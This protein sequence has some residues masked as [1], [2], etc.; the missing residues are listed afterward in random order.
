MRP[1][2]AIISSGAGNNYG[3]PSPE[4]LARLRSNGV[5]TY[6]TDLDGDITVTTDGRDFKVE[7]GRP[8]GARSAD[9]TAGAIGVGGAEEAPTAE[10]VYITRTGAKYHRDGCQYL[11]RSRIPISL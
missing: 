6:R 3:H 2:A 9:G 4:T 8:E 10:T 7:T 5:Q 11:R 1:R